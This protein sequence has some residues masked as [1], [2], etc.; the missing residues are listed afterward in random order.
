MYLFFKKQLSPKNLP[1][2]VILFAEILRT[3]RSRKDARE[4][5]FVILF[6]DRSNLSKLT[7]S[8]M[9]PRSQ[10]PKDFQSYKDRKKIVLMI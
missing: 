3:E 8:P 5:K 7:H 4:A 1:K 10:I 2:L 6:P 9:H